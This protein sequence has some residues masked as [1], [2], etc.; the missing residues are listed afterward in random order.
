MLKHATF[1]AATFGLAMSGAAFA[2]DAT[3]ETVV[4]TVNG[5]DITLGE[6]IITRA[7]LPQQY[8]QLPPD[9]LFDGVLDQLVQQQLLA[10][11][12]AEDPYRV[13]LSLQNER[14]ALLA[15]EVIND[16]TGAPVSDADLQSAYD[17]RFA[18][19]TPQQEY[20]ASHIL[21]ATEEEA[22]AVMA[23]IAAGADFAAT[24]TEISSDGSAA[25]GGNLG[26][27]S[28]GMMVPEFESAV[29][30]MAVGDVSVPVQTQFGWHIIKLNETRDMVPPTLD[31]LRAELTSELQ[32]KALTDLLE[33]LQSEGE[34]TLP[35]PGTFDPAL[36]TNLD[37]LKP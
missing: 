11:Q 17:A 31:E 22:L 15:G 23:R 1:M 13:T 21:V 29:K 7:R 9:V 8:Q 26:W 6:M 18:D 25:N 30:E 19:S 33:K 34:V 36:L 2:Q 10:G 37:L 12:V 14:R 4:A 32:Q 5:V 28:D 24:A 3:A 27:F 16:L 20:N 35:E